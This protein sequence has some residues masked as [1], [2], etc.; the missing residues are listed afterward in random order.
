[1]TQA[2]ATLIDIRSPR[3][4][5]Q[6]HIPGSIDVVFSFRG[7]PERISLIVPDARQIALVASDRDEAEWARRQIVQAG[8]PDPQLISIDDAVREGIELR[9]LPEILAS[10]LDSE[11]RAGSLVLDVREPIEWEMGHVPGACLI[12]LGDL[13]GRL[14]ELDRES[15][16]RVICEGGVRSA[17]AASLLIAEGFPRV[18]NVIDGTA[19]YRQ[20]GRPM[21][22]RELEEGHL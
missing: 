8:W 21:E 7:L 2:H 11:P 6:G 17:T 22:F 10:D 16:I 9:K 12:A 1:V 13:P 18:A 20:L 3:E 19:G 4:F 14:G 15:D 5:A